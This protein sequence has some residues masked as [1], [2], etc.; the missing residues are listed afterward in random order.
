MVTQ[1]LHDVQPSNRVVDVAMSSFPANPV[2]WSFVSVQADE[3]TGTYTLRRGVVSLAPARRTRSHGTVVVLVAIASV[4]T[5][6][7]AA[8]SGCRCDGRHQSASQ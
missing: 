2:C 5:C 3:A 8:S 4:N 6:S 7:L 1:A